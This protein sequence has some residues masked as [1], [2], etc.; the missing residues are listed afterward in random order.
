MFRT[1]PL[2]L[3][4]SLKLRKGLADPSALGLTA[5]E[6]LR[7]LELEAAKTGFGLASASLKVS[8]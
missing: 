7:T 2:K 6:I 5:S 1:F 4:L 3:I 8:P